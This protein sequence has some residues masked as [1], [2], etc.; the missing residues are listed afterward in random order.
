MSYQGSLGSHSD[1]TVAHSRPKLGQQVVFALAL[2]RR[3]VILSDVRLLPDSRPNFEIARELSAL[4]CHFLN[5]AILFL[6]SRDLVMMQ[7]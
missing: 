7:F 5:L 1:L 2:V 4:V 3:R 6:L